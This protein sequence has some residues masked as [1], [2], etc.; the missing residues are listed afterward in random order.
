MKGRRTLARGQPAR[1]VC[2]RGGCIVGCEER[3]DWDSLLRVQRNGYLNARSSRT[4]FNL[5]ISAELPYSFLH[6][7]YS[8]P[9]L[10]RGHGAL[11]LRRNSLA[12]IDDL[13]LHPVG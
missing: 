8:N 11:S 3:R 9:E 5:Q 7:S 2:P 6:A 12:S 4:G 13:E 1:Q 10:S